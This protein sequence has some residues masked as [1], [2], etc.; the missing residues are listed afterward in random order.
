MNA[1]REL[2]QIRRR[3]GLMLKFV[4]DGH[5]QQMSRMDDLE[6]WG[7]LQDVGVSIGR[8]EVITMLQDL[9]TFGY[10]T[11]RESCDPVSGRKRISEIELTGRGVSLVLN[12]RGNDEVLLD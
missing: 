8:N 11:F 2:I 9:E 7:M 12:R 6:M 4:R 5:E 10:L 3:R 1:N